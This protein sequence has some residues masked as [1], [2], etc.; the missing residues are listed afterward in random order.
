MKRKAFLL[1]VLALAMA[2]LASAD[3]QTLLLTLDTPNPQEG[4]RFGYSL[5]AGDVNGDGQADI[6]VGAP[7]QN[8]GD[9]EWQGRVYVFSGADGS[10]LFTL[11]TPNPQYAEFGIS[12]AMG[13]VNGDG[14]ADIAVGADRVDN[15]RGR[16]YVFSGADGSLL[17][18]LA[19]PNP[20]ANSWFGQALAVGDVN[21]DSKA[22]IA[23]GAKQQSV[24]GYDTPGQAY[25]FSGA[26]G[27]LLFTL[28]TPNLQDANRFGASLAVGNVDGDG[29]GDIAVGA[30][31]EFVGGTLA[32][33]AYVFSGADG[34]LLFTLD[35][36]NPQYAVF[37]YSVAV[38]DVNAD[39][40]GDIAVGAINE[41]VGGYHVGRA[42]VFSGA[43]GSLLFTLDTPFNPQ[44]NNNRFGNSL[45]VGDVNGD[46]KADIAVGA[47]GEYEGDD[48]WQGRA[49]VFSGADG[50]LLL[51]LNSP[52]PQMVAYFGYG[53]AVG[54]VNGDTKGDV[55]VGAFGEN[56]GGNE[57]QG[58]AYVFSEGPVEPT[59]T[60]TQTYTPTPTATATTT[61]VGTPTNTPT[62]GPAPV[63][64]IAEFPE[65]EPDAASASGGSSFPPYDTLMGAA[66]AVVLL[67]ASGWY[68]RRRRLT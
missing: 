39:G 32:G 7:R 61:P 5:A 18:T 60:P 53:L 23:V 55:A 58:Q 29:K 43:D 10:L 40:K 65:P 17:F 3:A 11:D 68:A 15:A 21:G 63:G 33:R 26:D 19:P 14:K 57:S 6:A 44:G 56:V 12:V 28:D 25:V 62:P 36:P 22:D 52:T 8:V 45:A 67:G 54:D 66:A 46:G 59:P 31:Q 24:G 27:S 30:Y 48:V 49:Y 35:T 20:Q 38:G 41:D 50:S 9:N 51:A 37:G 16:A 13:D 4:A 42:H 34:S 47:P 1:G 64:G 2:I